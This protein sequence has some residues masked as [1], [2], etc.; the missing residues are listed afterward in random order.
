MIDLHTHSTASDGLLSPTAATQYAASRNITVWA[1][2][3]HDTVGGLHEA[4][5]ACKNAGI[6]FVPGIEITVDW[7]TGEFH[8][9]GLGLTHCASELRRLLAEL[10]RNRDARNEHIITK[11]AESGYMTSQAELKA[12]FGIEQL[13]RPHFADYLVRIGAVKRRQEAFDRYLGQGRPWFVH[14]KG[15]VLETAVA[16]VRASGGVPV[17][18]HPLSLYVAW[19]KLESVLAELV[20]R[21][22]AGIEA[23]HPCARV[24]E[25]MRLEALSHKLG[26]FVTG[27]S[28]FHGENVRADR[29]IG[30]T[31]GGKKLEARL[32]TEEL[33]PNL[34]HFNDK[35]WL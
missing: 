24:G 27:G 17:L 2:T 34:P 1:L 9:L 30:K 8:L 7:P 26:C 5:I 32:W 3:D 18:A 21:G 22:I 35:S 33:L 16:A 10:R 15:A 13:G 20:S 12:L 25:A 29:K 23:W 31:S 14:H 11:M 19:G 4:A 28:D 6:T